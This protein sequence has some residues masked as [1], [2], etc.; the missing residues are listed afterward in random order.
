[1]MTNRDETPQ[2]YHDRK[3]RVPTP[4][5]STDYDPETGRLKTRRQLETEAGQ[6]PADH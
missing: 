5:R 1:M 2:Q 3:R 6:P 4:P